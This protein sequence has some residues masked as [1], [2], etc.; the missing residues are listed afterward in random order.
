[1]YEPAALV[2]TAHM[3]DILIRVIQ[4]DLSRKTEIP[5]TMTRAFYEYM[6]F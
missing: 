2:M 6:H 1:M 4:Q 3:L 5:V